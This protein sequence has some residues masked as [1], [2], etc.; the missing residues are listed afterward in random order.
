LDVQFDASTS[1]D[2]DGPFPLTY[3]WDLDGDG[4]YDDADVVNPSQTYTG[5]QNVVV[6][7]RVSDGM[8]AVGTDTVI[9]Q[10]GNTAPTVQITT[11][12][13]GS[14]WSAGDLLAF[15]GTATDAEDGSLEATMSW[16][17]VLHHC[18]T[19]TDCHEHPQ[20][21]RIGPSGSFHAPEHEYPAFLEFVARATDSRGATT[22]T[23]LAL[24]PV[25]S[26][27]T[28][29]TNPVGLQLLAGQHQGATPFTV[30]AISGSR[31]SVTAPSP[32]SSGGDT[33]AFESWS[34]G[35]AASH[36]VLA[37]PGSATYTSTFA[38]VQGWALVGTGPQAT[39][40]GTTGTTVA[41]PYPAGVGA[42]D[43]L[44]LGCQGRQNVHDWS[45]P[46][47]GSLARSTLVSGLR[48]E[49][50]SAW[51][52]GPPGGSL[53]VT[54]T[55]G[56]NGWSCA[57]TALRGGVGSGSPLDGAATIGSGTGTTMTAPTAAAATAG[58]LVTRWYASLDDNGHGAPS[59][60][61]LAFGGTSYDTD[62]GLDHG[63]SMAHLT[64]SGTGST[65]TAT[66]AQQANG[67]DPWTAI[68]LVL[69]PGSGP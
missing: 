34:D 50:L 54:N 39:Q 59:A 29:V 2:A 12:T 69:R 18:A 46:G 48:L 61:S 17:V 8:G 41:V 37:G 31:V 40:F 65:G 64:Q 28:F 11:P 27:L 16:S 49:V 51:A 9:I 15:S 3:A 33:Y 52:T 7:L 22:E 23:T 14:T 25:T 20:I 30:T 67:P 62:V 1:T 24:E 38:E 19:P 10:P 6:G 5:D 36:E 35:G 55:S 44:L 56:V 57:L 4:A 47:F 53:T 32:Q 26:S 21:E 58:A 42:G 13:A 68:T 66:M 43:L 63:A 45:A 60:G